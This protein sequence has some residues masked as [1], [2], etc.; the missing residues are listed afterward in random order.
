MATELIDI[1]VLDADD[2]AVAD[3]TVLVFRTDGVTIAAGGHT[4]DDGITH[5]SIASVGDYNVLVTKSRCVFPE[6]PITVV[7]SVIVP[8]AT[9]AVVPVFTVS[10][11]VL[12]IASASTA[13]RSTVY[14][15]LVAANGDPL[16]DAR[17][18]AD[19]TTRSFNT[20]TIASGGSGIDLKQVMVSSGQMEARTDAAGYWEF[21]LPAG[22]R[23][24]I[25]IP[26]SSVQKTFTV[27][28]SSSVSIKDV[29]S[30]VGNTDVGVTTDTPQVAR[31]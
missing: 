14:G 10:G 2:H 29:R 4:G 27:P 18:C 31:W 16:V 28:S 6:T 19:L 11:T 20:G 25:S 3:A 12:P 22:A 9:S 30:T 26:D 5:L 7:A 24:T 13:V 23:V 1:Q 17:V 8:P 15:Y 21:R